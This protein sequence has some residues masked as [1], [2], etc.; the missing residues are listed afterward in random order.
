MPELP[1]TMEQIVQD[2][3]QKNRALLTELDEKNTR[4][5][6]NEKLLLAGAQFGLDIMNASTQY[7][8]I[9]GAARFSIMQSKNQAAD[10]LYRGRQ[11]ALD[12]QLE[13]VE[14]GQDAVLALAA[15]G[16]DVQGTGVQ[17]IVR[18]YE[19]I[20]EQNAAIV[21][22]NAMR[23][24]LGFELEQVA[25]DYQLETARINRNQQYISSALNFGAQAAG[26]FV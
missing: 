19:A 12:T 14:Q 16:Q 20:A 26:A 24:A 10:A 22:A 5:Y 9:E 3:G 11:A 4:S 8:N 15:Q 25:T 13:G 23:E 6:R 1:M 18:S 7:R 21:E 2:E 17:R